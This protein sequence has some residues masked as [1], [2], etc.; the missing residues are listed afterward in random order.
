MIPPP[1][2]DDPDPDRKYE[3][4]SLTDEDNAILDRIWD[5]IGREEGATFPPEPIDDENDELELP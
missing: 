1:V 5:E 3:E 4:I 2:P